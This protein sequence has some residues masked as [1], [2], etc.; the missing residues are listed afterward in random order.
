[1]TASLNETSLNTE[2]VRSIHSDVFVQ[3][4][5]VSL[6]AII[7]IIYCAI[8]HLMDFVGVAISLVFV[9]VA[10]FPTNWRFW[11]W[12]RLLVLTIFVY[13]FIF[14][15]LPGFNSVPLWIDREV[16][17]G[18]ASDLWVRI[19]TAL[20]VCTFLL[21]FFIKDQHFKVVNIQESHI[22]MVQHLTPQYRS[23]I[24]INCWTMAMVSFVILYFYFH[25]GEV[26]FKLPKNWEY[27]F[28]VN[29]LVTT[30]AQEF[31]FRGELQYKLTNKYGF[32]GV[33]LASTIF[34]LLYLSV[35][36]K[37]ACIMAVVGLCSGYC[38]YRTQL[39]IASVLINFS[40]LTVHFFFL[41][42]PYVL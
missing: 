6:P 10:H 5:F 16:S 25:M 22:Q 2:E 30:L 13:A 9:A 14:N 15:L 3:Q 7:Y 1:M 4:F 20:I 18:L 33:L 35:S 11:P 23:Q 17:P 26:D 24:I 40:V 36:L 38:Y 28:A 34:G 29:L 39:I 8:N 32:L 31:F 37:V 27:W 21:T 41:T 19:D 42:Y 12:L